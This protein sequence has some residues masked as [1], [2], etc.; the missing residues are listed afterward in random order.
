[1]VFA[2]WRA[3]RSEHRADTETKGQRDTQTDT[4][5]GP[6]A[7]RRGGTEAQRHRYR[8]ARAGIRART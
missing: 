8:Q 4:Q 2:G 6:E 1:M 7:R 3:M 5:T